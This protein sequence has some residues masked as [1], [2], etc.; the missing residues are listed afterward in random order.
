MKRLLRLRAGALA[1]LVALSGCD[2]APATPGVGAPATPGVGAPMAPSPASRFLGSYDLTTDE[3]ERT[4]HLVAVS[5]DGRVTGG[6]LDEYA[7]A[8]KVE[9]GRLTATGALSVVLRP[10]GEATEAPSTDEVWELE[11]QLVED[12]ASGVV[13]LEGE[14]AITREG[15][16][17]RRIKPVSGERWS[18]PPPADS[19]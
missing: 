7:A 12:D 15:A 14:V 2:P 5:P 9:G 16:L 8:L 3:G 18:T 13:R 11:A 6:A 19:R 17:G 10:R 1:A 4:L